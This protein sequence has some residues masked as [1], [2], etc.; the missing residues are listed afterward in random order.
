MADSKLMVMAPLP[1]RCARSQHKWPGPAQRCPLSHMGHAG[2]AD[3]LKLDVLDL[4][5]SRSAIS[6][7]DSS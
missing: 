4:H 5:N 2:I 7:S 6:Y 3:F 1:L